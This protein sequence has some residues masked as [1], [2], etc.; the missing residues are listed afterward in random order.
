V[1]WLQ[2]LAIKIFRYTTLQLPAS[3]RVSETLPLGFFTKRAV[4]VTGAEVRAFSGAARL[5]AFEAGN[6]LK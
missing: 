4:L 3:Q 6:V 5:F 1:Q 2:V